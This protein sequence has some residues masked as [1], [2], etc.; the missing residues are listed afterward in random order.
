M[1]GGSP[2]CPEGG[3]HRPEAAVPSPG[4]A[5]AAVRPGSGPPVSGPRC[6]PRQNEDIE[7]GGLVVDGYPDLKAPGGGRGDPVQTGSETGRS[8]RPFFCLWPRR[9][10]RADSRVERTRGRARAVPAPLGRGPWNLEGGAAPRP[11]SAALSE[12][13]LKRGQG[14]P[15]VGSGKRGTSPQSATSSAPDAPHS[16]SS[17]TPTSSGGRPLS[18]G[19][20]RA[21]GMR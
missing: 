1:R 6:T 3:E 12:W 13:L 18:R 20:V 9:G 5:A 7:Q 4:C 17:A 19:R 11:A 21:S 15:L 8:R 2:L 10:R 16:S 14:K